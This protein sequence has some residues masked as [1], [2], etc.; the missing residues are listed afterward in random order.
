ME[1]VQAKSASGRSCFACN[2]KKVRCDKKKPCTPC[3]RSGKSCNY[4]P[5]GPRTRRS[6]QTIMEEMASRIRNLENALV[7]ATD[8]NGASPES[9]SGGRVEATSVGLPSPQQSPGQ[10]HDLNETGV[11]VQKGASS[12]YFNDVLLSRALAEV[13]L[14]NLPPG[15]NWRVAKPEHRKKASHRL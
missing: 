3:T 10:R 14:S 7:Q 13:S 15:T 1:P 11:L 5:L 4:P 6:K 2:R 12:H 8:A 9:H